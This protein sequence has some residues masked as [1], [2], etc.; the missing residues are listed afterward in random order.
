MNSRWAVERC[1]GVT[2]ALIDTEAKHRQSH[3]KARA[4]PPRGLAGRPLRDCPRFEV[5]GAAALPGPPFRP[6]QA[7]TRAHNLTIETAPATEKALEN[8]SERSRCATV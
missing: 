3:R 5:A 1:N 7:R 2:E 8:G 4:W 6:P